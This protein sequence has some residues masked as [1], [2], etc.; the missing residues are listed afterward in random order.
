MPGPADDLPDLAGREIL[1]AETNALI[2]LDLAVNILLPFVP[3]AFSGGAASA[4]LAVVV[5]TR[6]CL[7][8]GV[9]TGAPEMAPVTEMLAV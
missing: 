6:R 9:I 8:S 3:A 4:L 5:V 2:A 7:P 1:I